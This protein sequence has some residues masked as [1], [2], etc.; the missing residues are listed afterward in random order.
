MASS[1]D[2][3]DTACGTSL[4]AGG[5]SGAGHFFGVARFSALRPAGETLTWGRIQGA[6][7]AGGRKMPVLDSLI[8]A[9]ALAHSLTVVT[10]NDTDVEASGIE[11]VD[12]WR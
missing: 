5:T 2:P 3:H 12:P 4:R 8:A 6:A 11:I 7:E 1:L 9:T 10:R